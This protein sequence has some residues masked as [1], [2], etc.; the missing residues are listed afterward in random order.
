MI[1]A[2]RIQLDPTFKQV[3]YFVQASGTHR[4][5]SNWA[6]AE[7]N[8]LYEAGEKPDGMKLRKSFNS[9]YPKEFPW[10]SELHRDC[11]SQP[12]N[13]LQV[14]FSRYFKGEAKHPVFKK[15]GEHDS[16]YVANDIISL[17][18]SRVRIPRLGWVRMTEPLRFAGKIMS[19]RVTRTADKWFISVQVDIGD[20]AQS[21]QWERIS[22]GTVGVDL[23]IKHAVVTSDNE[24]FDGPKPLKKNL[25]KLKRL[26]RQ[27]ARKQK[28]S[29]NRHKLTMRLARLHAKIANIRKD[30][31]HKVTTKICRENQTIVLE[32]LNVAGMIKNHKL[33]R[34]IMDIGF[35]E[36]RRQVEYKSGLY[37]NT[38]IL[39]DRFY[40]SSKLC[41]KCGHKKEDLTLK[42]RTYCCEACGAEIDRDLNAALNLRNLS[43][44]GLRGASG[45]DLPPVKACG[46]KEP[47][48][49]GKKQ[50]PKRVKG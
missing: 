44:L 25:E 21:G 27:H 42:D 38:L 19:A 7:W 37:G 29:K 46:P 40:P 12:F 15:K 43:T 24:V 8:R 31:L 30:F 14:A 32:D 11:H 6:L 3:R 35:G 47:R 18:E 26:Q 28:G 41:S 23:G 33:A 10:I 1:L 50:E 2:H 9:R 45:G 4:F 16:F 13:D 36:F 39:A 34:A 22:D 49:V 5:V 17:D 48:S 20:P